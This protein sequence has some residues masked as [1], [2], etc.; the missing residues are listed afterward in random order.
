MHGKVLYVEDQVDLGFL[1]KQYL[2]K[3]GIEVIWC[4]TGKTALEAYKLHFPLQGLIIIDIQLPD[5]DG[6]DLARRIAAQDERAYFIFLTA[7]TDRIDRMLGLELGA[8]DYIA[9]P[10]EID[11]LVLRVKNLLRHVY[12]TDEQTFEKQSISQMGDITLN[13]SSLSLMI[14]GQARIPLTIREAEL[15]EYLFQR[16]NVVVRKEDLLLRFWGRSDYFIGRSLDVFISRLRKFLRN[17]ST[18]V[19]IENVYGVGFIMNVPD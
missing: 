4:T 17:S 11:E 12:F 15:L 16:K 3:R 13:K 5:M 9:K 8:V 18:G 14:D 2:E 10:F 6:F 19:S 1:T 7:R